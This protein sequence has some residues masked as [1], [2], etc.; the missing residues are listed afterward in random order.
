MHGIICYWS[1]V[2]P[3]SQFDKLWHLEESFAIDDDGR[4][5][6]TPSTGGGDRIEWTN[7]KVYADKEAK[8]EGDYDWEPIMGRAVTICTLESGVRLID[9]HPPEWS[10]WLSSSF[11]EE[12]CKSDNWVK[13]L[14]RGYDLYFGTVNEARKYFKS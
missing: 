8:G 7:K 4:P 11:Y 12:L 5:L 14:E 1:Y 6:T 9:I 3:K 10:E 2:K 13:V